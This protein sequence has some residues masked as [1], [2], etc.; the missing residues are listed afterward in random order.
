MLLYSVSRLLGSREQVE[1]K[2]L[3]ETEIGQT[4]L[5]LVG[6]EIPPRC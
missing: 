1:A 5:S 2:P 4:W 3:K 6:I